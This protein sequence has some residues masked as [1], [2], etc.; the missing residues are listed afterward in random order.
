MFFIPPGMD[1]I[2]FLYFCMCIKFDKN[3]LY[4][5]GRKTFK[6]QNITQET[7]QVNIHRAGRPG[8]PIMY[9]HVLYHNKEYTIMKIQNHNT[10]I[11]GL[12]DK[13]DFDKVKENTWHYTANAYLSYTQ[14]MNGNQKAVYLH[15]MV[16]DRLDFPGKGAKESVDHINRNGLDNRKENLRIVTQSA[17]NINQKQKERHI[18]LPADSGINVNDIPKHVWYI[19]PNGAHGERFGIDLKTEKIKWKTTSAKNVSLKDK[20]QSA[21][22]QLQIY[23]QQF[24]YLNPSNEDKN[25]EIEVLSN[26]YEEIVKLADNV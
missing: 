16:M 3:I 11:Y 4:F 18:E 20:L 22:N 15:N 12:I 5:E 9:T 26:S 10:Y 24:P 23:Y 14:R 2:A 25:K 21:K 8:N 17:Q 7:I 6:M 19:K 1:C 13:E